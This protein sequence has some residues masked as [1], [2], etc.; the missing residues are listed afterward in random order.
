MNKNLKGLIKDIVL[1]FNIKKQKAQQA[2]IKS[3]CHHSKSIDNN[4]V[5]NRTR[6]MSMVYVPSF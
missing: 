6:T 1:G 5:P 4:P 2:I 3:L